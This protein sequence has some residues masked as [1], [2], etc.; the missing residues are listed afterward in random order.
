LGDSSSAAKREE[1]SICMKISN[2][3]AERRVEAVFFL[4]GIETT[5][6]FNVGS[7][8]PLTSR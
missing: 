2:S 5:R 1:V 4:I 6:F 7:I 8:I 3:A